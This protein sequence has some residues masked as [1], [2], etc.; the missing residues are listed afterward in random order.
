MVSQF[1]DWSTQTQCDSLTINIAKIMLTAIIQIFCHIL[2][3][4]SP[5]LTMQF[6]SC[7]E[8]TSRQESFP[9]II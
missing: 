2:K 5:K 3:R 9:Q 8:L 1:A 6:T 7:P 4:I